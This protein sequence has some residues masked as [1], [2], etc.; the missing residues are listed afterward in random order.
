MKKLIKDII[1]LLS[2]GLTDDEIA[3]AIRNPENLERYAETIF[4]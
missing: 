3:E 2:L 1:Y 4:N